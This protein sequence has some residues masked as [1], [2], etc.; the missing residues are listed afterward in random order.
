M[1]GSVRRRTSCNRALL[2]LAGVALLALMVL[3]A[4]LLGNAVTE[5][6]GTPGADA[7]RAAVAAVGEPAHTAPAVHALHQQPSTRARSVAFAVLA[8]ALAVGAGIFSRQRFARSGRVRA[9]RITG[10]PSGRAPPTLR[11]A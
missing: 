3:A 2:A 6:G 8:A 4:V 9:L 7:H 1:T 10:L 11:I 5:S